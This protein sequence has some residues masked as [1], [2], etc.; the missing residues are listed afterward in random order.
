MCLPGTVETVRKQTD[1]EGPRLTRRKALA[2]AAGAALAAAFPAHALADDDDGRR[3]T[4]FRDLT[5]VF[6][7]GFPIFGSPPVFNSPKRRTLVN[8][9]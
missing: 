9:N 8:V 2:G 7:A 4:R 3:G 5:H 1:E 6:A